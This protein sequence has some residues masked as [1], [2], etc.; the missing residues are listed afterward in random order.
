MMKRKSQQPMNG[1]D[2]GFRIQNS[3]SGPNGRRQGIRRGFTLIEVLAS[4]AVL[5]VLILALTRMFVQAASITSNGLTALTRNSAGETAMET[6]L[7]DTEGMAVNE[8][9]GAYVEADESDPSGFG[10]DGAWFLTTSGDQDDGRAYQLMHYY[11]TNAVAT[12]ATG[13]TYKRFMLYR[14]MWIMAVADHHSGAKAS[15]D[16]LNTN[17]TAWWDWYDDLGQSDKNMLADNV[18]RFDIYCLG[19]DGADWMRE[20]GGKRVFDSTLGPVGMPQ[21]KNIPPAA[22]D[23]YIQITSPEVAVESGMALLDG[24]DPAIQMKA[25]EMMIRESSALFGRATPVI[26]PGQLHHPVTH[27]TDTS[28]P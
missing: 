14:E 17:Q 7:Q 18:V 19:W 13:A 28:A 26:G 5:V 4:M 2:S 8:R 22:F 6:I 12:N 1:K 15:V 16:V 3:E 21:F 20:S 25:R 23:V 9:I 10:F 24:V 11:V 27:Y